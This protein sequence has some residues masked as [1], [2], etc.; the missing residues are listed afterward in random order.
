MELDEYFRKNK[1]L[2]M[3]KGEILLSDQRKKYHVH[4]TFEKQKVFNQKYFMRKTTDENNNYKPYN[5]YKK[6]NLYFNKSYKNIKHLQINNIKSFNNNNKDVRKCNNTT[7]HDKM[8]MSNYNG[9]LSSSPS[10]TSATTTNAN[11]STNKPRIRLIKTAFCSNRHNKFIN[12]S[13]SKSKSNPSTKRNI[14]KLNTVYKLLI[15]IYLPPF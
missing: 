6:G 13:N 12:H 9:I 1:K 5:S 7:Q 10:Q 2:E 4:K 8:Y 15:F 11:T 3:L 14:N